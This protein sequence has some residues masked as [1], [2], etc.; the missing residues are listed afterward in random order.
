M[1]RILE[2]KTNVLEN[3]IEYTAETV[4]AYTP[5]TK[6]ESE[7]EAEPRPPQ[8]GKDGKDGKEG[9]PGQGAF[10]PHGDKF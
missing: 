10:F 5:P 2:K 1:V 7:I 3:Y 9:K 8:D 6:T 4:G